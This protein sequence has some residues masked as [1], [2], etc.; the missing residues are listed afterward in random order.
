MTY[1]ELLF[2]DTPLSLGQKVRVMRVTRLLTQVQ[3]AELASVTQTEVS[4]LERNQPVR[5]NAK[6]KILKALGL[7]NEAKNAENDTEV[8]S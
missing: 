8:G 5:P 6:H 3:L 2:L 1:N 4:A 7:E